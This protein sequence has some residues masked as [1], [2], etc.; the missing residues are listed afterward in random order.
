[1]LIWDSL[2]YLTLFKGPPVWSEIPDTSFFEGSDLHINLNDYVYDD[3]DPDSTLS[4]SIEGGS[5]IIS[6]L[7][8]LNHIVSFSTLSDTSGFSETFSVKAIDPWGATDVTTFSISI[9]F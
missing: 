9:F 3:G 6:S 5:Q 7:D 2:D 4:I 8:G 1:M